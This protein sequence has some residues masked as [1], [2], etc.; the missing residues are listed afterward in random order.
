MA[1]EAMVRNGIR[2]S[3]RAGVLARAWPVVGL[4]YF[5]LGL[6]LSGCGSSASDATPPT[7][8]DETGLIC[9][10]SGFPFATIAGASYDA[11]SGCPA[12][13]GDCFTQGFDLMTDSSKRRL[14]DLHSARS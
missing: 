9:Q 6:G 7:C 3:T 11:C 8:V 5:G 12:N 14:G 10:P 13:P 1:G 2:A 4:I